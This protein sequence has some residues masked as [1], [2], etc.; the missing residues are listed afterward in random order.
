[1]TTRCPAAWKARASTSALVILPPLTSTVR[2]PAAR[3]AHAPATAGAPGGRGHGQVGRQRRLRAAPRRPACGARC[4]PR[5]RTGRAQ[6]WSSRVV[7]GRPSSSR[8]RS[9]VTPSRSG[10]SDLLDARVGGDGGA[11]KAAIGR[12]RAPESTAGPRLAL[13][14]GVVDADARPPGRRSS[15]S[16]EQRRRGSRRSPACR[17]R[18]RPGRTARRRRPGAA[19]VSAAGPTSTCD[20]ARRRARRRS[21]PAPGRPRRGRSRRPTTPA[22]GGERLGHRQGGVAGEHADLEHPPGTGEARRACAGSAPSTW[23]ESISC[24]RC[25]TLPAARSRQSAAAV[26]CSS[27][28]S[29]RSGPATRRRERPTHAVAPRPAQVEPAASATSSS[30]GASASAEQVGREPPAVDRSRQLGGRDRSTRPHAAGGAAREPARV[31]RAP[32]CACA[33]ARRRVLPAPLAPRRV[34]GSTAWPARG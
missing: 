33:T 27:A 8:R 10:T 21:T 25:G 13:Q 19:S 32:A 6:P 26:R 18:G 34:Y 4:A 28:S 7:A 24:S 16:V 3:R 5:R 14:Q 20:C 17:R 2:R 30:T 12:A 9:R 22:A 1:M 23:P 29:A 11:L 31:P 15:P